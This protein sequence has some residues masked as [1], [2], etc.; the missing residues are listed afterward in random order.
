MNEYE[1][2][3]EKNVIIV[4]PKGINKKAIPLEFAFNIDRP[5][6]IYG[7]PKKIQKYVK[8]NTKNILP[9]IK[10]KYTKIKALVQSPSV[11]EIMDVV[12]TNEK[13]EFW[14]GEGIY[15]MSLGEALEYKKYFNSVFFI[16]RPD[17]FGR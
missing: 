15:V 13:P 16:K 11:G 12:E 4:L 3:V 9:K 17:L 8:K 14:F 6:M 10:T 2:L 7:L 5:F 1:A